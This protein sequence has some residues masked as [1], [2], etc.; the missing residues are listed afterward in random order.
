[1]RSRRVR[2]SRCGG[3]VVDFARQDH[4]VVVLRGWCAS[5]ARERLFSC[6]ADLRRARGESFRVL[7]LA[8]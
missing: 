8:D 1:M 6:D 4:A 2:E 3:P 7:E 5:V